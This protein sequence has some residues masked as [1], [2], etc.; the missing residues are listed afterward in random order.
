MERA[1]GPVEKKAYSVG[2]I[3]GTRYDMDVQDFVKVPFS[4][5]G[6][7][8]EEFCK[9]YGAYLFIVEDAGHDM[10]AKNVQ[11]IVKNFK[12]QR[13][14]DPLVVYVDYLQILRG[15]DADRKNRLDASV[16]ALKSL[17]SSLHV[18]VITCSSVNRVSY[19]S[20]VSAAAYKESGEIEYTADV[21]LGWNW[22]G[23]T[24][25]A[26]KQDAEAE[27]KKCAENGYRR[28]EL[29]IL[30]FRNG[31]RDCSIDLTY[32]PAYHCFFC[33]GDYEPEKPYKIPFKDEDDRKTK[34]PTKA[35]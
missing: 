34:K 13:P 29:E 30:K 4:A 26:N 35:F 2:D 22:R 7:Y 24:D 25:A 14:K 1:V 28:M 5:Y 9:N 27:R 19:G 17:A 21:L 20:R 18:P 31:Q 6:M 12:E 32:Y 11:D 3:L 16:L 33:E 23:V 15:E 8:F 10:T